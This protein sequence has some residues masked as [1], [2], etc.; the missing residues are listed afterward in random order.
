M[1]D[2]ID[3]IPTVWQ[4]LAIMQRPVRGLTERWQPFVSH[5]GYSPSDLERCAA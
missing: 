5:F 2:L 1:L 3:E 4:R